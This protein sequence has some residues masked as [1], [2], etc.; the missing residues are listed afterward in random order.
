MHITAIDPLVVH[1][2]RRGDWVFLQVH[3]DAGITGLG[4][5]SHSG[6]DA[7]LLATVAAFAAQLEG[8]DPLAVNAIW[9]T[10]AR[11]DGGR[12][13][14]TALSAIEQALWDIAGQHLGVPVHALFGGAVR[15]RVRLYANINR[16][17]TERS[18][19]GFARAARQAV[20]EGFGAI[21]LAPFDEVRAPDHVRTGPRAAW[22]AGV[23][24]VA[25]VRAEV[26]DDIDLMVDC[27]G[28][29]EPSEAITVGRALA[30]LDLMWYEEPVP[31][32]YPDQLAHVSRH[33]PMPTASAESVF[34]LAG[35]RPFLLDRVVDVLMPDVKHCGGMAA[36]RDIARA[37]QLNHLL[38]APHNPSGPLATVA[39]AHVAGTLPNALIL[40]Y[41]WG[42][43]D[44]RADLLQPPEP[45]VDGALVLPDAPGLG[46]R[47]NPEVVAA[48]RREAPNTRDSTKV[49][50]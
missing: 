38:I 29:M 41:A 14:H 43:A 13:A 5:A 50:F 42:E 3:T 33:V 6:N 30:H 24:R 37:A 4:E 26:G 48:H 25:A 34:G 8:R 9:R 18:P 35:F 31:H 47:L 7:L 36:L 39:T 49:W 20:D 45:I 12:V 23:A 27:H 28:R 15:E 16:H 46:H 17:V 21:K 40:E 22:R 2:S 44:W 1:V 10:L 32:R 11:V 19:E